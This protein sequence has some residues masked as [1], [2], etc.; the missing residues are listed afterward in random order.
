MMGKKAQEKTSAL[1][2][3]SKVSE[4]RSTTANLEPIVEILTIACFRYILASV[5][6]KYT[7]DCKEKGPSGFLLLGWGEPS[8]YRL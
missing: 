1:G 4:I 2:Q 6:Y 8:L 7:S 5:S 3:N